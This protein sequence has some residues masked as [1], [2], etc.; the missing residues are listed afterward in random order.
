MFNRKNLMTLSVISGIVG[1][2]MEVLAYFCFHFLGDEGFHA[3]QPEA[4]KPFVTDMIGIFG[5]LMIFAC[6]VFLMIAQVCYP[7][8]KQQTNQE[9]TTENK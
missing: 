1:L 3:W 9:D 6:V 5:I 7:K 2:V 8:Q 4:G